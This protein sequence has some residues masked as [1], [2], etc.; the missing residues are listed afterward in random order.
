MCKMN[1][2]EMIEQLDGQTLEEREALMKIKSLITPKIDITDELIRLD[3]LNFCANKNSL[4]R[5]EWRLRKELP[6]K[7][8]E[9]SIKEDRKKLYTVGAMEYGLP[10]PMTSRR[11][12]YSTII[13]R[14][15]HVLNTSIVTTY[16][17]N[18]G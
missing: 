6:R 16:R 4:R 11:N 3:E 1:L 2:N 9:S 18:I 8:S 15:V 7:I 13:Q 12:Y 14:Q 17:R 5:K 10:I